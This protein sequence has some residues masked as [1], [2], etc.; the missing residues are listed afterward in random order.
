MPRL[1]RIDERDYNLFAASRE[2]RLIPLRFCIVLWVEH[3]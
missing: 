1:R 2:R 3:D